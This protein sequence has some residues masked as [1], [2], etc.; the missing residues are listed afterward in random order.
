MAIYVHARL[1]PHSRQPCRTKCGESM[2][3]ACYHVRTYDLIRFV[4]LIAGLHQ[5]HSRHASQSERANR[6]VYGISEQ[7]G[8]AECFF[9]GSFQVFITMILKPNSQFETVL[10]GISYI[11]FLRALGLQAPAAFLG[12]SVHLV[13]GT[14]PP[15]PNHLR[16]PLASIFRLCAAHAI[17]HD[18]TQSG[19]NPVHRT[20]V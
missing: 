14:A 15:S 19:V 8:I 7:A 16:P 18:S 10:G 20:F 13:A 6:L 2:H 17:L 9:A 4:W 11:R 1:P 5:L 12:N 3:R